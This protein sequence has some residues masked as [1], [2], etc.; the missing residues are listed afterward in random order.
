MRYII[1]GAG[2]IGGT[3]GARLYQA[4]KEV[5]LIARG[6]HLKVMQTH[7]LLLIDPNQSEHLPIP[8]VEHPT[9]IE[10]QVG[11]VV[12]L[13]MK[14]QHTAA[15]LEALLIAAGSKVPVVCCQNGVV[16]ERMAL[17]KFDVVY[18][19]P[20]ILPATHIEPGVVL[21]H[22]KNVGGVLD[23]GNY[24]DGADALAE[25]IAADLGT[26]NFSSR[27]DS[28]VMSAKYAKLLQN[29]G[30]SLQALCGA[31]AAAV[32]I[33]R[34]LVR[35]AIACYEAAG[36]SCAS[37]ESFQARSRDLLEMAPI[38]GHERVGGSTLQSVLRGTGSIEVDYLN[39]EIVLLGRLY[40]V[41]TPANRTVQ[42][43]ANELAARKGQ[44]GT[45]SVAA[46]HEA[47]EQS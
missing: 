38:E 31:D 11:D 22:C 45:M 16:N 21:H 25:Q 35:E 14:S 7:G 10:F 36:I 42:V 20:V 5:V 46:L 1:Y 23:I 13:C 41:S 44:P 32:E 8:V 29:L 30:N 34:M 43:L 19:M 26:A 24:P 2:G 12:L 39:G 3:I 6:E 37:R 40:G 18:A 15:A 9:E 4:G 17:R 28:N 27:V 47:I 33:H